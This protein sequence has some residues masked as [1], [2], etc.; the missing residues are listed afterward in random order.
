MEL[1]IN[2]KVY[3]DSLTHSYWLGDKSLIGVTSLMKKH[4]L[5][6]NYADIPQAVLDKAAERGTAVH[7]MLED[8]DNGVAVEDTTLIK[9]YRALGLKVIMSEYLVSDNAVV[10]SSIDKVI[11]TDDENVVDLGD[12]K[13]TS[14]LHI[15]PLEWQLSIYAYLFE[16][17][18]KG[19]KVRNLYAIHT[20]NDKAKLVPINRLPDAEVK[21]LIKA[22]KDGVIYSAKAKEAPGV[23]LILSPEQTAEV[24]MLESKLAELEAVGAEIK[25]R[26]DVAR[27]AIYEYMEENNLTEMKAGDGIYKRKLPTTRN[28]IDTTSLK[29]DMPEI[30]AKYMKTSIV[31]GSI[32][33]K[34]ISN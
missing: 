25:A 23:E 31:K 21:A 28:S 19:M 22:E 15:G 26:L 16:K 7:K 4:G 34:H 33:Y 3:F 2:K 13:N 6:A 8:Y 17:Q 30:A 27:A 24:V 29:A 14:T 5:S 32:S 9:G 10:A 18:N 20:H 1:K 11:A 12:V